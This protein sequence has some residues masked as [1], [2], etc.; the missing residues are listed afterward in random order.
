MDGDVEVHYLKPDRAVVPDDKEGAVVLDEQP[1]G[2]NMGWVRA[3]RGHMAL[4][5]KGAAYQFRAIGT[6]GVLLL[7]TITGDHTVERWADICQTA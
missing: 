6:P 4:L 5:P 2:R 7:Q 3:R 1:A